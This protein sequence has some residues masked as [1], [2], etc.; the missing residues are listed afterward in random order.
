M[1]STIT[2]ITRSLNR[3]YS[4]LFNAMLSKLSYV[5]TG[6]YIVCYNSDKSRIIIYLLVFISRTPGE[7]H[8]KDWTR[9]NERTNEMQKRHWIS[10]QKIT[11]TP[12]MLLHLWVSYIFEAR[13]SMWACHLDEGISITVY[14]ISHEPIDHR[15]IEMLLQKME[16][17]LQENWSHHACHTSW[18]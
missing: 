6:Q 10:M 7:R 17:G 13:S 9:R 11:M 18:L 1:S 3:N 12:T 5:V 8:L 15:G 4:I 16:N 14:R 2:W